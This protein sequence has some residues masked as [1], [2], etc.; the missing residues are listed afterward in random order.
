MAVIVSKLV[1]SP[2]LQDY[3]VDKDTGTPLA[4]GRITLYRDNP[5][6]VRKNWFYQTGVPGA[7]SYIPLDNPMN[8]SSVGTIQDPNGNDVIPFFY[9]WSESDETVAESYYITVDS[10]DE[11]GNPTVRQFTRENFPFVPPSSG[12]SGLSTWRNYIVNNEFWHNI[13][14]LDCATVA[15][16]I[17]CPSQ[18]D[19]YNMH[20][21]D[22]VA[23]SDIRW[24]R[25]IDGPNDSFVASTVSEPDT[26]TFAKMENISI[27]GGI[28]PEYYC[29]VRCTSESGPA[30]LKCIQYPISMHLKTLAGQPFTFTFWGRNETGSSGSVD[31]YLYRFAG[32]GA[33]P[34]IDQYTQIGS[35]QTFNATEEFQFKSVQSNF[36]SVEDSA[37]FGGAGDDAYFIQIRFP[38]SAEYHISHTKPQ[39][40]LSVSIPDNDF[41]TY[42]QINAVI[43]A[44]RTCDVRISGNN[45]YAIRYAATN[46]FSFGWLPM[47][48]GTIGYKNPDDDEDTSNA[49][50]RANIDTWQLYQMIWSM[51]QYSQAYAP[52][53]TSA[54]ALIQ[55]GASPYADFF[56]AKNQLSLLKV[57][58]Q[59]LAATVS[60]IDEAQTFTTAF[61]TSTSLLTITTADTADTTR[62]GRGTPVQLFSSGV[63]PTGLNSSTTYYSYY[64]SKTTM[65]LTEMPT[66]IIPSTAS[67]V[68][69]ELPNVIAASTANLVATYNNGA[70]GVGAFLT[71]NSTQAAFSLDGIPGEVGGFYLI[72]NQ[73]STLENGIYT[74]LNTAD[75]G[76]TSTNWKLTR[77]VWY[78]TPTQIVAL[79]YTYVQSGSVAQAGTYWKET[80]TVTTVGTDPVVFAEITPTFVTF[81]SDGTGTHFIQTKIY[82]EG[83]V[84]GQRNHLIANTDLPSGIG[85]ASVGG[86]VVSGGGVEKYGGSGGTGVSNTFS[87]GLPI[88]IMQPTTYFNFFIKL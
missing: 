76:S 71:N 1:S 21:A 38:I 39:L 18:H 37:N 32:T 17:V 14:A 79:S 70:S 50:T 3:L 20:P 26:V 8:L 75:L 58:G 48:N 84:E 16:A 36:P 30:T 42:D 24:I 78:D 11:N 56:T 6:T 5:R 72:K 27:K 69:K 19:N 82:G 15:N 34:T 53:Y 29:S 62:W 66:L 65:R 23:N 31:I 81:S 7:Y 74:I 40:F 57:L 54:G 83:V 51:N 45:Y 80:A 43:N 73:T 44:P 86:Q 28:A 63:L 12:D 52:M 2:T 55:Y 60:F 46:A 33:S 77:A 25:G 13:G 85:S 68:F 22:F 59:V 67:N 10:A 4:N 61:G 49:T 35:T 88:G 9:P 87:T 64:V 41:D 47:N